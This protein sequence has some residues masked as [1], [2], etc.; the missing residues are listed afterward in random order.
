M[1]GK[2]TMTEHLNIGQ[3]AELLGVSTKTLRH[4]EKVGLIQPQREENGYRRYAPEDILRM[5]RIRQLQNLGLSLER[6]RQVLDGHD[7]EALWSAVLEALMQEIESEM[8]V[9]EARHERIAELLAE[10]T[11]DPLDV[12]GVPL[13]ATP[14]IQEYLE[15]HLSPKM[16]LNEQALD[17]LLGHYV[18]ADAQASILAMA[19]TI[20]AQAQDSA[21]P[22]G[23]ISLSASSGFLPG[24]NRSWR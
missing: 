15:K 12:R 7:D 1:K 21:M 24:V 16:W 13:P 22:V 19:E 11:P 14:R 6:V 4:Y 10:G 18:R 9:L 5:H 23:R 20:V 3:A 2:Y 17:T 8:S